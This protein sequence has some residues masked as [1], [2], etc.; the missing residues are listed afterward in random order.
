MTRESGERQMPKSVH[1]QRTAR[2]L[3]SLEGT[4]KFD[5]LEK[6][7]LAARILA[8]E[9]HSSGLAGQIT[10]RAENTGQFLTLAIGIGFDEAGPADFIRID[11]DLNVVAGSGVPNPAT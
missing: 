2:N 10:A 5:P 4:A 7:T 11:D 6:L 3:A 9:G 8:T 1:A